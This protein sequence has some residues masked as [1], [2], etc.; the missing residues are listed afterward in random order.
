MG[1]MREGHRR[2]WIA[3]GRA[4]GGRAREQRRQAAMANAQ[5]KQVRHTRGN[6][7]V[8]RVDGRGRRGRWRQAGRALWFWRFSF[9]L[10]GPRAFCSLSFLLLALAPDLDFRWPTLDC[11]RSAIVPLMVGPRAAVKRGQSSVVHTRR[12]VPLRLYWI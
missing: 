6:T 1:G 11:V 3:R 9:S 12:C 8:R 2:G 4:E 10:R 5:Q 7:R